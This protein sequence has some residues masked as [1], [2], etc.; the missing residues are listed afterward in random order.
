[1]ETLNGEIETKTMLGLQNFFKVISKATDTWAYQPLTKI[2]LMW[3][4]MAGFIG[5][6]LRTSYH[7]F[8]ET[9]CNF[10]SITVLLFAIGLLGLPQLHQSPI[11][12]R[13]LV[14]CSQFP[15][16]YCVSP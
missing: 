1:M 11:A 2:H 5:S 7:L 15:W 14:W 4:G 6:N 13:V 3:L 16:Q 9:I 12:H 8:S 10:E